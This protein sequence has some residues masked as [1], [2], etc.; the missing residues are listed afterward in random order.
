VVEYRPK[1][2]QITCLRLGLAAASPPPLSGESDYRVE[3]LNG[4]VLAATQVLASDECQVGS[5]KFQRFYALF[6]LERP[7]SEPVRIIQRTFQKNA[8]YGLGKESG[9]EWLRS[10]NP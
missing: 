4:T 8:M 2:A 3:T 9:R 1:N 7:V 6:F 5:A 10:Y